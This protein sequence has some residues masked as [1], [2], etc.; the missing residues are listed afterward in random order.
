[1]A[2]VLSYNN[3]QELRFAIKS[4]NDYMSEIPDDFMVL[5]EHLQGLTQKQFCIAFKA[6]RDLVIH[7]YTYLEKHPEA[8]GLL[9]K[10]KKSGEMKIQTSQNISSIKKI[11]YTIGLTS[12]LENNTLCVDMKAFR[13]SYAVFYSNSSTALTDK[14]KTID[15]ETFD[16]FYSTKH[17]SS[18]FKYL[19]AFGFVIDGFIEDKKFSELQQLEITFPS[20]PPIINIIKAFSRPCICRISFGFDYAKFN[21]RIFAHGIHATIPM[22]DLYSVCLLPEEHQN[23]LLLLNKSLEKKNI[24]YGKCEKGWYHGTLPCQYNYR[25]KVRVLQNMEHGILPHLVLDFRNKIDKGTT[26]IESIPKEY[27]SNIPQCRGCRK[28]CPTRTMITADG[29][30]YALCHGQWWHLP[31]IDGSIDF[32][33]QALSM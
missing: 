6:L 31:L 17:V 3:V 2:N 29:K 13:E 28:N 8:I 9:A 30:K 1:M 32:I 22:E 21:Y 15:S 20:N 7:M 24:R 33:M 4:Y 11:I 23:F 5:K 19:T 16:K 18:I 25:N 26:L 12:K 10:H 27:R 14:I